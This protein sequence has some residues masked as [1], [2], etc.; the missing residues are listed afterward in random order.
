MKSRRCNEPFGK[1]A[2]GVRKQPSSLESLMEKYG[3]VY[4][5]DSGFV[6]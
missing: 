1:R 6:D 2:E 4:E 5:E 3:E